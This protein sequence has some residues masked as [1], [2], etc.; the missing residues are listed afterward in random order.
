MAAM[1]KSVKSFSVD[2][3]SKDVASRKKRK[4][5]VLKDGVVHDM[6]LPGK[7]VGGSWESEAGDTTESDSVDMKKKFL[8]KETSV[9]YRK[10]DVLK[11]KVCNQMPNGPRLVTKQALG[12]SLGKINFLGNDDDDDILLDKPVVLSPSLKKLVDVSARKFFALDIDLVNI[13]RKSAQDKLAVIRKLFSK[14]NGFGGASTPSKFSGIIQRTFT[15]E[16]SLM[17]ATKLAADVKILVNTDLKKSTGCSDQAVVLKKIL[18]GTSAK[19]VCTALAEFS[20]IKS[21]KMQLVKLW[22]KVI[23]EFEKQNQTD[24]LAARWSILIGKD[25]VRVARSD[26]DKIT[27]DIRDYYRALLYTLPVRTNAYDIW[28]FIGSVD[29]KTCVID[30]HPVTYARA[31]CAVV[32]FESVESLDA[33]M[34]TTPMLKGAHLCWFYLGSAKCAK[35][36]KLGHTSLGC[37]TGKKPSSGGLP[38]QV[39]SDVDKS[40]LAAIYA[41]R[42]APVAHPVSFGGVLWAKIV[43]RSSFPPLLVQNVLLNNGSS[44]EMKPTLQISSVLNNRF[45]A[46]ERSLASLAECVDKLTKR[47]NAPGPTVSQLNPGCQPL[48]TPLLQN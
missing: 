47:L 4:G 23:I 9:D 12:K 13:S 36:G 30:Y 19:T 35:Y 38:C 45:A 2:T 33:V 34:E 44:S 24:L 31:R 10:G 21:I 17:K 48:V 29:G 46:F 22:Q 42:S 28:D 3:V 26:L 6:V 27:W 40:K 16:S 25:A 11:R 39:L 7:S 37:V 18:V 8:I 41:K 14:I 5:D 32:C 20:T 43:V 1:K 15:S